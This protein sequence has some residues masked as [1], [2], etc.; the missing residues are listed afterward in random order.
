M[1]FYEDLVYCQCLRRKQLNGQP[2]ISALS[3]DIFAVVSA[4][5]DASAVMA[6]KERTAITHLFVTSQLW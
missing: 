1:V 6:T 3:A 4:S 2:H 5:S